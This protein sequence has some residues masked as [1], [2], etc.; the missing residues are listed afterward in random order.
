MRYPSKLGAV[1]SAASSVDG[2]ESIENN[3]KKKRK[4]P[5]IPG[6]VP[7]DVAQNDATSNGAVGSYDE[8][9]QTD[10]AAEYANSGSGVGVSGAGRGRGPKPAKVMRERHPLGNS[11]NN[12]SNSAAVPNQG[13][14]LHSWHGLSHVR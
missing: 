4:I 13:T 12:Q 8:V 5:I 6:S 11:T 9:L 10:G 7:A 2:Y 14:L 3:N 1:H